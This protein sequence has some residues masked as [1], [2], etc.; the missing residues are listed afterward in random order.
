MIQ[1]YSAAMESRGTAF[2]P[3]FRLPLVSGGAWSETAASISK[4]SSSISHL[5]SALLVL[6]IDCWWREKR[7]S[8]PTLFADELALVLDLIRT[9]PSAG[10]RSKRLDGQDVRRTLREKTRHYVYHFADDDEETA[11]VIAVWATERGR[12]PSLRF[13]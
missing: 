5:E 8:A 2:A 9:S 3:T 12:G 13:G 1:N 11:V 4:A 7:P 10:E 6:R